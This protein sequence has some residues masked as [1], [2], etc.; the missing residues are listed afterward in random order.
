MVE[1]E[2]NNQQNSATINSS[3]KKLF[4]NSIKGN[5]LRIRNYASSECGAKVINSNKEAQGSFKILSESQDEYMLNPCNAKI[6]F[7]VELCEAIKLSSVEVANYELYSSTFRDFLIYGSGHYPTRDWQLVGNFTANDIKQVQV[8]PFAGEVEFRKFIK[9]EILSH[10]GTEHF[11]PFSLVRMFGTSM[12]DEFDALDGDKMISIDDEIQETNIITENRT[13]KNYLN[14]KSVFYKILVKVA[15]FFYKNR[16]ERDRKDTK[17]ENF[18]KFLRDRDTLDAIIEQ[19]VMNRLPTLKPRLK[20]CSNLEALKSRKQLNRRVQFCNYLRTLISPTTFDLLI[21]EINKNRS[22]QFK[23]LVNQNSTDVL[24]YQ[25]NKP[26]TTISENGSDL[27]KSS[28]E[29]SMSNQKFNSDQLDSN[30]ET[31]LKSNN[32][33]SITDSTGITSSL[34]NSQPILLPTPT[35]EIPDEQQSSVDNSNVLNEKIDDLAKSISERSVELEDQKLSSQSD[36]ESKL[37]KSSE[38]IVDKLATDSTLTPEPNQ[39]QIKSSEK[40]TSTPDQ[41]IASSKPLHPSTDDELPPNGTPISGSSSKETIFIRMINKIKT[42]ELNLSLSSQYLEELSQRYRRQMDEMQKNFNQTIF[43]LNET[44]KSTDE[45]N[46]RQQLLLDK[47]GLK[48]IELE[49]KLYILI[50]IIIAKVIFDLISWYR[51]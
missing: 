13:E 17:E 42:L 44:S 15:E 40:S 48:I 27:M 29:S 26:N 11:C 4:Q 39:Q 16:P 51:S 46:N 45:Y 22:V 49:E 30:E 7:I 41:Q 33:L 3:N 28:L 12:T 38:I 21:K 37:I 34:L 8:F 43:K 24:S 23:C 14:E 32:Y 25:A 18:E 6:W 47:L 31:N 50:A 9:I 19:S 20:V 36:D 10:H 5:K 35:I 1:E 2:P